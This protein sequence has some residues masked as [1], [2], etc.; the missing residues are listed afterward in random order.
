MI[1]VIIA[2]QALSGPLFE[3]YRCEVNNT[4][5]HRSL[6]DSYEFRSPTCHAKSWEIVLIFSKKTHIILASVVL[7]QY[8]RVTE[9]QTTT[10]SI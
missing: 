10:N 5:P 2:T 6:M 4:S 3:I 7:L 1:S 8:T 9:T